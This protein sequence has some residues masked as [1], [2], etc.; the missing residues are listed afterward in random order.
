MRNSNQDLPKGSTEEVG[1]LSIP[2]HDTKTVHDRMTYDI[3]NLHRASVSQTFPGI[4]EMV[5]SLGF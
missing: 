4:K 5:K 2:V 3:K 1:N